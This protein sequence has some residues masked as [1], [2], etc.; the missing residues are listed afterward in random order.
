MPK[1]NT[2]D[3]PEKV[4]THKAFSL[5]ELLIVIAIISLFGFLVFSGLK[6]SE[7]KKNDTLS[8]A[9]LKDASRHINSDK[10]LVCIKK[11][12]ECFFSPFGSSKMQAAPTLLKPLIVYTLDKN[13]NPQEIDFG[14]VGDE[15]I[16]LRFKYYQNGSSSQMII[17][18]EDKFYYFPSY[19]ND[20]QRTDTLEEATNKWLKNSEIL[21]NRGDFY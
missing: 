13:N 10:E 11:C 5:I 1:I 17:E 2:L 12:K 18:S 8:I 20:V 6:K 4:S 21:T 9:K 3:M 15:K 7:S 14:R 16:C 19:F